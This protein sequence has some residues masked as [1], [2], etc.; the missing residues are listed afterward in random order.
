VVEPKAEIANIAEREDD[1]TSSGIPAERYAARL[2][3]L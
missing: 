3:R 2:E 1:C